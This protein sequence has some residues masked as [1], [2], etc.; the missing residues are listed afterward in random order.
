VS[1][2]PD[3]KLR[4]RSTTLDALDMRWARS[5][6]SCS[7]HCCM[8]LSRC[9]LAGRRRSGA[10]LAYPPSVLAS[11]WRWSYHPPIPW[12]PLVREPR[13]AIF[14]MLFA[15]VAAI[16]E[17]LYMPSVAPIA[18]PRR[19]S[20]GSTF[21]VYICQLWA[22]TSGG[23]PAGTHDSR[24]RGPCVRRGIYA[25]KAVGIPA[26]EALMVMPA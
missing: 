4:R 11:R 25:L 5:R 16:L 20:F 18:Y 13:P 6:S 26:S 17:G 2:A 14:R 8:L 12:C 21:V 22:A 3:Q 23:V 1:R 15:C 19:A 9:L 7:R 10:R 24:P